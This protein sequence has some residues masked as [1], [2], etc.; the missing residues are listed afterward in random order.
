MPDRFPKA[1]ASEGE[2][3]GSLADRVV[4]AMAAAW[5]ALTS[6][7]PTLTVAQFIS[8][9]LNLSG[10]TG[11]QTVTT[12]TAAAIVAAL[13]DAQVGTA[14]DFALQ[15]ANTSSGAVTLAAGAGVTLRGTV[16]VPITKTQLY[17]G[18]VTNATP[19]AEAVDL[20]GLLTAAI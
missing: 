13:P 5:V 6:N 9:V 15:N 3:I 12:P 17:K 19:G 16:N 2:A 20:I 7:S 14:F 18:V 11:A 1:K 4:Q 10:Q 8:A